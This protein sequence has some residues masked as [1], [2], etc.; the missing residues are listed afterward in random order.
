MAKK[1]QLRQT[2]A[3]TV[4]NL[5]SLKQET[6]MGRALALVTDGLV[7]QFEGVKLRFEPNWLLRDVVSQL[8]AD[9]PGSASA[10]R[11]LKQSMFLFRR[12]ERPF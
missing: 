3:G 7:R 12:Y 5:T 8:R 4:I 2:R 9:F 1:E 10:S 11:T 6:E